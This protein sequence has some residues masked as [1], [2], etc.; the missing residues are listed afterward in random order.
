MTR[1]SC[2]VL[3]ALIL[4]SAAIAPAQ[5]VTPAGTEFQVNTYTTGYQNGAAVCAGAAGSFVV[6]WQSYDQDGSGLGVFGQRYASGGGP[7]GT[8]F[9][10]N[11]YTALDQR[12]PDVCCDP[13]GD[14]VAV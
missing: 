3:G 14:F 5:I 1:S 11:T 10:I 2:A 7:L 9:Q 8:E 6:V 13:D 12:F 4:L